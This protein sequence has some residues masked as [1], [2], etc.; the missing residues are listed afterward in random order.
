MN[1]YRK[2]YKGEFRC[3][4]WMSPGLK[5]LLSRLLDTNPSTRITMEEIKRDPWFRKG[6]KT[7]RSQEIDDFSFLAMELEKKPVDLNAF[8]II[9]FSSGLDLS[10]M[11]QE[12]HKSFEDV[13]R[14][15]VEEA[16]E[17]VME[18]VMEAAKAEDGRVSLRQKKE[19]GVE[20]EGRNGNFLVGVEVYRLTDKF[21]VVEVKTKDGEC[22]VN[23]DLWKDKIRPLLLQ[24]PSVPVVGY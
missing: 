23:R 13:E 14:L 24:Q 22:R 17:K 9:S 11:F 18:K 16:P 15:K 19:W 8:D 7:V 21:A 12:K 20:I 1:M 5:R 2:I 4:K 3:P 6:Y 10:G